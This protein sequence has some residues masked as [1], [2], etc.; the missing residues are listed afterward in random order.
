MNE[1]GEERQTRHIPLGKDG[2]IVVPQEIFR[3]N[4]TKIA[5][6]PIEQP[7]WVNPVTVMVDKSR[8][9]KTIFI[10]TF[11]TL[12]EV[13]PFNLRELME[14][15]IIMST[16]DGYMVDIRHVKKLNA[17][18]DVDFSE[19]FDAEIGFTKHQE[20]YGSV[21][22]IAALMKING[23]DEIV[24][25]DDETR[26]LAKFFMEQSDQMQAEARA[27]QDEVDKKNANEKTPSKKIAAEIL[28]L[29]AELEKDLD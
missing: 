20:T 18:Q 25:V 10:D 24:T 4:E 27:M 3:T 13:T 28:R 29:A 23:V 12:P 5:D 14:Y 7:L 26:A 1:F 8:E 21:F 15:P 11:D 2:R 16:L 19:E 9:N 22:P 6:A 17:A